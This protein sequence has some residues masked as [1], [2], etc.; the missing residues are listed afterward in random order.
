[1]VSLSE[2]TVRVDEKGRM[3]IPAG[4]REKLNI[5]KVVK[6]SIKGDEVVLKPVEDPLRA[7]EGL[8]EKGTTDVEEE[9]GRLRRAAERELERGARCR[10]Y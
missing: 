3:V 6:L 4:I 10:P 1:M 2:V 5:K 9:I 8:V 7:L